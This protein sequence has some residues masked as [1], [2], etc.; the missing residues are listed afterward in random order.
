M[1]LSNLTAEQI[2]WTA[3]ALLLLLGV[4]AVFAEHRRGKRRDIDRV[5]W[6]PWNFIQIFALLLALMAAALALKA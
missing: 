1:D 5:G 3:A 2:L 4:V 6:V